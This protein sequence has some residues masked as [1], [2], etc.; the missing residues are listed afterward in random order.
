MV[1][2][3]MTVIMFNLNNYNYI[4][5]LNINNILPL[6]TNLKEEVSDIFTQIAF[7]FINP[8]GTEF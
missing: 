2:I 1:L 8:I 4:I 6:A 5:L 3:I 7:A